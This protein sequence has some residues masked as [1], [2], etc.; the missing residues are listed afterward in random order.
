MYYHLVPEW[1][2]IMYYHDNQLSFCISKKWDTLYYHLI[3][4]PISLSF[5]F[6]YPWSVSP[7][8][9]P[10]TKPRQSRGRL[11]SVWAGADAESWRWRTEARLYLA[12]DVG[13]GLSDLALS[14]AKTI[15]QRSL[16]QIW[17]WI[18][19]CEFDIYNIEVMNIHKQRRFCC[20]QKGI[21][22]VLTQNHRYPQIIPF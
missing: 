10:L 6:L 11:W 3:P 16:F 13:K 8:I 22:W 9:C 14:K 15:Q 2:Y 21:P 1:I 5:L 7:E 18:K 12:W 19:T 17:L 4:V 20:E